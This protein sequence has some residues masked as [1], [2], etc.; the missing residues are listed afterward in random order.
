MSKPREREIFWEALDCDSAPERAELIERRCCGDEQLRRGVLALLDAHDR[1]SM[2]D[3][4]ATPN[5]LPNQL[6]QAARVLDSPGQTVPVPHPPEINKEDRSGLVIGPY[7]LMEL[8]GEGGF[9]QVYVAEQRQPVRR[10]VAIKLLKPGMNSKEVLARFELERQALAMMHHPNIA[11]VHDAGTTDSGQPYLVMELIRGQPITHYC[12][13][14]HLDVPQKLRLMIDVCHAVGHAHQKGIIH[15]DIKPSNVL[16]ALDDTQPIVKIIDFGIAKALD[17]SLT[18]QTVYTMFAQLIGTPMYMSPEQAEMKARD[19][20]TLSDVYALGVLLYELLAGMPPFDRQ[21]IQSASFDELRRIIREVQ[22]LRPSARVTTELAKE[23]SVSTLDSSSV[24]SRELARQLRG[25]L[26][27]IVLKAMDK[28]R[29]R[30][31]DSAGEMARDLERYLAG[32]PVL[33]RSPTTWY[34]IQRF[35]SRNRWLVLTTGLVIVSLLV[36]TGVSLRLAWLAHLARDEADQ[37]RE[38]AVISVANLREANILLDSARSNMDQQRYEEALQQ[39]TLATQ[40][41]PEHY[42]TW[43]GRGA[44][45]AQ[46]GLWDEAADDY[47][48]ALS[49]GAPANNPGWWGVAPLLLRDEDVAGFERLR[50]ALR[51]QITE[52]NDRSQILAAARGLCIADLEVE[53]AQ[54]IKERLEKLDIVELARTYPGPPPGAGFGPP[55]GPGRRGGP[56]RRPEGG[57]LDRRAEVGPLDRRFGGQRPIAGAPREMVFCIAALVAYRSG[58]WDEAKDLLKPQNFRGDGH[59]PMW[60]PLLAMIHF[61]L[62]EPELARE[63]LDTAAQEH[64]N[65]AEQLT[66]QRL[67]FPWYDGLEAYLLLDEASRLIHQASTPIH[68]SISPWQQSVRESLLGDN[69]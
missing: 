47:G 7:R 10:R 4:D 23:T 1:Q 61:R 17:Q 62:N 15:R 19:V 14:K 39:Y 36:G 8:L 54:K 21:K 66:S 22:P 48:L 6:A 69:P 13:Q 11:Q 9:G 52:S 41:Q 40:L 55:G 20:D 28:D 5:R 42:L 12:R 68:E 31:Y 34:T 44:L 32:Q 37:L 53:E 57:P 59:P 58:R 2:L 43:A 49:L 56:P 29:R 46:Q 24:Q 26:D 16:V 67:E 50:S 33:A 63:Q 45:F 35:C 3:R 38:E 25:D 30:R 60:R 27:W 65:W 64:A 51:R 18:E